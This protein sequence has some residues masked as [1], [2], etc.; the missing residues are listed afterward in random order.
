MASPPSARAPAAIVDAS[1]VIGWCAKEADKFTVA[2]AKLSEYVLGG[3]EFVNPR[4]TGG[5]GALWPLQ[6]SGKWNA[7]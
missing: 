1:F 2:D 7:R 6:E 5:R 3:F 4:R